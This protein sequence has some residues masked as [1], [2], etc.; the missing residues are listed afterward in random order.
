VLHY[1]GDYDLIA[2]ITGQPAQWVV[3]REPSHNGPSI[4]RALGLGGYR[5]VTEIAET[6]AAAS[7]S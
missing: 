2:H 3:S 7:M 5:L 1:D 4:G 6:P